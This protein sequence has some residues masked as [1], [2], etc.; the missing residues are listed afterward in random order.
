[1]VKL[2]YRICRKLVRSHAVPV[3]GEIRPSDFDGM[4]ELWFDDLSALARAR[5]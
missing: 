1:M 5:Q 4:A 3:P 2:V